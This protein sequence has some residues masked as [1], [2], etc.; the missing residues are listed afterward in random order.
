MMKW[1]QKKTRLPAS[2][3]QQSLLLEVGKVCRWKSGISKS[4][5]WPRTH[6]VHTANVG[7]TPFPFARNNIEGKFHRKMSFHEFRIKISL[8]LSLFLERSNLVV[9]TRNPRVAERKRERSSVMKSTRISIIPRGAK[10][11]GEKSA[12]HRNFSFV[13]ALH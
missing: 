11:S 8:S 5:E 13:T 1:R 7:A 3:E 2:N 12:G 6:C 4:M 10:F 9:S